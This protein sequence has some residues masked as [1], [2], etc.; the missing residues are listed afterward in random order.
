MY[1]VKPVF[2]SDWFYTVWKGIK[3]NSKLVFSHCGLGRM[4][5]RCCPTYESASLRMFRLG[6]TE[7]IRSASNASS[8]FVKAFDDPSR[9]VRTFFVMKLKGQKM[10]N[11]QIQI[12]SHL[13]KPNK[14]MVI[15]GFTGL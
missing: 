6:R 7:T 8:T 15:L 10:H 1:Y 12:L 3:L 5:Q 2:L 13:I 9:Q 11:I 14:N 4:Y